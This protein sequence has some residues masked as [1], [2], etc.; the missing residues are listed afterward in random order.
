MY[1]IDGNN[2]LFAARAGLPGPPVGRQQLCEV[3]GRWARRT[4]VD[5][6]IV[7]DGPHPRPGLE[8]QMLA[9][10]IGVVFSVPRSADE[11]IEEMIEGAPVPSQIRVV[12]SDRAI[13]SV[14]RGRRCVCIESADFARE[15]G[16]APRDEGAAAVEPPPPEKP[17]P[18][19]PEETEEWLRRFNLGPDQPSDDADLTRY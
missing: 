1:L 13:Q 6:T 5:L 3:L 19:R 15:L 12:T 2:L 17:G 14:A 7:F 9:A 11:V 10:K 8:Q 4:G 18:L 16:A